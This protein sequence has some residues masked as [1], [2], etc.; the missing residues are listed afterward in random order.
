MARN[1]YLHIGAVKT[2]TS[3]IQAALTQHREW[4]YE[5]SIHHLDSE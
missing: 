4:L 3:V 2:G 5:N 1:L